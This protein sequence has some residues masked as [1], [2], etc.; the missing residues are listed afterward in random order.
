MA[1]RSPDGIHWT[2]M[3]EA[4]VITRGAFD[5][6][7]LAF[8]D[9]TARLYREYHRGFRDGVRDIMTGTSAD[10]LKWTGPVFLEYLGAPREHLYTNAVQPYFRAPHILIGFPTRFLP[11]TEQTEPTFMASRDGKA[12]RRY[13]EAV[14]PTTAPAD[15]DGNR[16]N[17]MA[18]GLLQLPGRDRELSVYATEAYYTGRG[19]RVRRFVYRL[20]GFV[21]LHA[22]PERGEAVTRPLRFAGTRLVI[23]VRTIDTGGLRVGL[24]DEDGEPLSGYAA[25]QCPEVRGDQVARTVAWDAGADVSPLAGRVIRIRFVLKD[26]DLFSF[27]FE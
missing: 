17:Y 27:R 14:I 15:R 8:W 11:A 23:N 7:N 6:Q 10:F 4:P 21:A 12:F 3:A 18:W 1:L 9:P 25:S 24:Q 13:T 16:C 19:S 20:D 5:S 26:A 2:R 22:G